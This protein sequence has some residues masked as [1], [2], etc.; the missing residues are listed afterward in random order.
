MG[1]KHRMTFGKLFTC[2][3]AVLLLITSVGIC[4]QTV[5]CR[6]KLVHAYFK[7]KFTEPIGIV[8]ILMSDMFLYKVILD[9]DSMDKF[10]MW[11]LKNHLE[12]DGYN[13][14]DIVLVIHN[15]TRSRRFSSFDAQVWQ[16]LKKQGF[17]GKF[18]LYVNMSKGIY[19]LKEDIA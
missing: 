13:I 9:E 15:H 6:D 11:S 16:L 10:S 12:K 5:K 4:S 18:Y 3:I 14:S 7:D 17:T 1:L 8:Y 19:E 2:L